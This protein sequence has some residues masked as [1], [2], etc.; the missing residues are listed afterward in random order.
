MYQQFD[1][2][3]EIEKMM[4]SERVQK[5]ATTIIQQLQDP[6]YKETI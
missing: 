1:Y 3:M 6:P 4:K 2:H 5:T